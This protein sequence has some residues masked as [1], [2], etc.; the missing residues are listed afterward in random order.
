MQLSLV[1]LLVREKLQ[2]RSDITEI[3]YSLTALCT[4][5]SHSHSYQFSTNIGLGISSEVYIHTL[6]Q[7]GTQNRAEKRAV[8]S[9]N[10]IVLFP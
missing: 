3:L 4:F 8:E 10:L 7:L 6:K 1:L 2:Y 9:K 5:P